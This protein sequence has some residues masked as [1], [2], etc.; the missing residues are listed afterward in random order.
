MSTETEFKLLSTAVLSVLEELSPSKLN[1]M[2]LNRQFNAYLT[3]V[4]RTMHWYNTHRDNSTAYILR[5]L[6]LDSAFVKKTI[7]KEL[8]DYAFPLKLMGRME[9][10]RLPRESAVIMDGHVFPRTMHS[11][12][13]ND[14]GYIKR[15]VIERSSSNA[16]PVSSTYDNTMRTAMQEGEQEPVPLFFIRVGNYI[17]IDDPSLRPSLSDVPHV[18]GCTY[19]DIQRILV[20]DNS[21]TFD[22]M[23][24]GLSFEQ[25]VRAIVYNILPLSI[26]HFHSISLDT[27]YWYCT[28]DIEYI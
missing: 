3:R 7:L 17:M 21:Y 23:L 10:H 20:L 25:I 4:E 26:R 8:K 6:F 1:D 18:M 16:F 9:L 13:T 24:M 5:E 28:R 15:F 11:I 2:T 12:H 22:K 14:S 19:D 27:R